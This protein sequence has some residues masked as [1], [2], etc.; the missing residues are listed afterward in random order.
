MM[1]RCLPDECQARATAK[2]PADQT[3]AR[4]RWTALWRAGGQH[5]PDRWIRRRADVRRRPGPGADAADA[6][7]A[8]QIPREGDVLP[9]R[10]ERPGVSEPGPADRRRR[11]HP[12]QPQLAAQP[13]PRH[14]EPGHDPRGSATD[15]RR[16]PRR[17]AGRDDRLPAR[18]GRQLHPGVRAGGHRDG[19]DVDLLAGRPAR[20]GPSGRRVLVRAPGP[21]D[22]GRR[23]ERPQGLDRVV[24]RLRAAGH[25]R[26]LPCLDPPGCRPDTDSCR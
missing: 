22:R 14:A 6:R 11:P 12:V 4:H 26:R 20:L 25:D 1:A 3:Q 8:R 21:G 17:G 16:H 5:D 9:G 15:E 7:P 19:D 2:A 10:H 24:P 18:A 23:E 13:D